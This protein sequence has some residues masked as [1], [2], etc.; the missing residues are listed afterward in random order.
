MMENPIDPR[1]IKS[2]IP[3]GLFALEPFVAEYFRLLSGKC[4]VEPRL[5]K[6]LLRNLR[7]DE[8]HGMLSRQELAR[9]L[10][11]DLH[12]AKTDIHANCAT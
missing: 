9:D 8:R 10:L 5:L 3:A 12:T 4:L 7:I 2:N 11:P 1:N 6:G